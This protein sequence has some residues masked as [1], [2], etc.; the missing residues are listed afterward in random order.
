[1]SAADT[2][3]D[4]LQTSSASRRRPSVRFL[5]SELQVIFGRRRTLLV[6]TGAIIVF[7]LVWCLSIGVMA[8]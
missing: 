7:G 3:T 6:V 1:M 8:R 4:V 5:L 2:A